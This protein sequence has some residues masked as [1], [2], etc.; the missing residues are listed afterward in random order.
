MSKNTNNGDSRSNISATLVE[1]YNRKDFKELLRYCLATEAGGTE[2]PEIVIAHAR[3]LIKVRKTDD[4]ITYITEKI[5]SYPNEAKLHLCLR[6]AYMRRDR[7]RDARLELEKAVGLDP[8]LASKVKR[9]NIFRYG[10]TV[11][12]VTWLVL[13]IAF[14]PQFHYYLI[15][16]MLMVDIGVIRMIYI[17]VKRRNILRVLGL[18]ILLLIWI[19]LTIGTFVGSH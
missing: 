6:A 15:P 7:M 19:S 4:A 8:S 13:G 2:N 1:L 17:Y 5:E 3:A 14:W 18:L 16:L 9:L 11:I 10:L 12:F